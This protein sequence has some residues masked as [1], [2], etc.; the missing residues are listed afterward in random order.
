MPNQDFPSDWCLT[1]ED[2]VAQQLAGLRG[3]I[4]EQERLLAVEYERS[5]LQES[6]R[7][8]KSGDIYFCTKDCELELQIYFAAP[9]S[10]YGSVIFPSGYEVCVVNM[11]DDDEY[12]LWCSAYP[13]DQ[14]LEA[15]FV[16][17]EYR[18]SKLPCYDGFALIISTALLNTNFQLIGYDKSFDKNR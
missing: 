5:L 12:P 13:T 14:S 2:L 9:V 3:T 7:F 6:T 10:K 16:P 18:N 1:I 17:V 8:P 11:D 4:T 15:V